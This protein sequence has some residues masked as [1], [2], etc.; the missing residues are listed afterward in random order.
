[1]NKQPFRL[2]NKI[3]LITGGGT[4]IGFGIASCFIAAGATVVITGRREEILKE[5]VSKLGSNAHYVTG[6]IDQLQN[7]PQILQQVEE[8]AGVVDILVNNAGRNQK[9]P[10]LDTTN[11]DLA[12]ILQTNVLG[13]F[14]LS[15]EVA[16]RM[17]ENKKSGSILLISSMAAVMG[18]D[19][20]VSYSTAKSGLTGMMRTMVA[21]LAPFN[22]RIN[23]IAPGWIESE[24]L[25]AALDGDKARKEKVMNRIPAKT[26]GKPEDIG[27]A[28]LFLASGSAAYISGVLLPVDGGAAYNF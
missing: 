20:V 1:M 22:I 5:A 12:A 21:D 14:A 2:D 16:R 9:K 3:A 25:A 8:K 6:D 10:L 13:T 28:A 7:I 23:A 19:R 24:M 18:I 26:L 17:I 15:R 4:G 11:E 27:Y